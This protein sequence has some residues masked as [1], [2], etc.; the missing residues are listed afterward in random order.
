MLSHYIDMFAGDAHPGTH[1]GE[2]VGVATLVM[3]RLQNVILDRDEPPIL[4]PTIVDRD[5]IEARFGPELAKACLQSFEAKR[6]DRE[7]VD[8]L[9]EKLVEN[10][11]EWTKELRPL[12]LSSD[13][14]EE[15]L[16]RV[17]APVSATD[18]GIPVPFW[19]DAVRYARFTRDRFSMLDVAGDAGDLDAFA[20]G[21]R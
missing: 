2:Q 6:F 19:Q 13:E 18:L 5:A 3:N 4:E 12:M 11:A 16:R 7:K 14:I 15:A 9:N 17:A 21:C 10:W 1:H 8:D 20:L